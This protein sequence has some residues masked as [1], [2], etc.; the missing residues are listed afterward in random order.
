[1]ALTFILRLGPLLLTGVE[2][3]VGQ[4]SLLPVPHWISKEPGRV[5]LWVPTFIDGTCKFKLGQRGWR[6][7][8]GR[9]GAESMRLGQVG[10][11][12]SGPRVTSAV[13]IIVFRTSWI[14]NASLPQAT[15]RGQQSA[16]HKCP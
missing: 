1:M 14:S 8:L 5:I 10:T 12:L 6:T 4:V 3:G 2:V 15:L 7:M 11:N 13:R 9:V 16:H